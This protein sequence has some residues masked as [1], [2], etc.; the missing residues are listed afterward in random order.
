MANGRLTLAGGPPAP[1]TALAAARGFTEDAIALAAALARPWASVGLSGAVTRA[2]LDGNLA[3]LAVS[4]RSGAGSRR[5][6]PRLLGG[7]ALA[8]SRRPAAA[9]SQPGSA[10]Q[11]AGPVNLCRHPALSAS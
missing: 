7:Q 10:Q 8:L 5:I 4:R 3:A 1:V 2:Q 11:S 6:A 9:R